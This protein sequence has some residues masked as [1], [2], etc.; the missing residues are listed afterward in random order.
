MSS[1]LGGGMGSAG[2]I[3]CLDGGNA[4][5]DAVPVGFDEAVLRALCDMDVSRRAHML[6]VPWPR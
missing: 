2:S 6:T 4:K 5:E 1:G 3:M